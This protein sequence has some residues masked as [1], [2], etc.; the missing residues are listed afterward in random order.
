M[1]YYRPTLAQI[2]QALLND[3]DAALP[4]ANARLRRSLVGILATALAGAVHL[5]Y[6]FVGWIF[7]QI[8]IDQADD[9]MVLR[10][11]QIWGVIRKVAAAAF[12]WVILTGKDGALVPVGVLLQAPGGQQYE[13]TTEKVVKDGTAVVR[14]RALVPGRA[15]NL[16]AGTLSLVSPL[17]GCDPSAVVG[18]DGI[19]G[20]S[21]AETV[22]AHRARI[23]DRIQSPPAGGNDKDYE[24]WARSVAGVDDVWVRR[25]W[26]GRGTVGVLLKGADIELCQAVHDYIIGLAPVAGAELFVIA[27]TAKIVTVT[28]AELEPDTPSVRMA[29]EAELADLVD[30]AAV[31]GGR[32]PLSHVHEAISIAPGEEDHRVIDPVTAWTTE[33]H[34]ILTFGGVTWI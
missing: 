27:P 5:L 33:P 3:I 13:T 28:I 6:S 34:E 24:R 31:P 8:F 11:G 2:R 9:E 21:D 17:L 19:G 23:L 1:A 29:V 4:G 22:E 25:N 15:G 18:G 12:G 16:A 14:V 20:G 7:R 30:R 26:L 10:H 32:I